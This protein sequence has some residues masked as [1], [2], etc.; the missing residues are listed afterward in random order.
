M[1]YNKANIVVHTGADEPVRLQDIAFLFKPGIR[2]LAVNVDPTGAIVQRAGWLSLRTDE[3]EGWQG[4]YKLE[5]TYPNDRKS[6]FLFEVTR[7]FNN[8]INEDGKLW[9]PVMPPMARPY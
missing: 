3:F 5:V 7:T 9:F 4:T 2:N 6:T 1:E 8:P